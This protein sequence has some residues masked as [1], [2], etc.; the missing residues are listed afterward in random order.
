MPSSLNGAVR[1]HRHSPTPKNIK[2]STGLTTTASPALTL[3]PRCKASLTKLNVARRCSGGTAST[4]SRQTMR[5]SSTSRSNLTSTTA[6]LGLKSLLNN[7]M[8]T[9]HLIIIALAALLTSCS[10][11]K[12]VVES[13][14]GKVYPASYLDGLRGMSG[15][16]DAEQMRFADAIIA[17]A[18]KREIDS[19]GTI[20]PGTI[21]II[22]WEYKGQPKYT[23]M[24]HA[25]WP[26]GFQ[27]WQGPQAPSGFYSSNLTTQIL[28]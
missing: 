27:C 16:K 14:S 20:Y 25:T 8:K 26:D 13:D 3:T 17:K 1:L 24:R 19:S 6:Q 5:L 23:A 11:S 4:A 15:S 21:K 10:T 2:S 9:H 12:T 7:T 22:H 18:G 28:Q